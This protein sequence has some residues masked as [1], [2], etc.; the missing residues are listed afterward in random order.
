MKRYR[1]L[2]FDFDARIHTLTLAI[3][4]EWEEGIKEQHQQAKHSV[5]GGLV[6]AY[7]VQAKDAKLQNFIE[8]GDKPFSIL[9]FHNPFFEQLR[10]A[11]VMGAY[12]PAL[13]AVCS[14][15]ERILNYLVL[16][17]SPS[18]SPLA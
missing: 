5:E 18:Y 9:A 16:V 13:T 14:L 15:G 6:Y 17:L 10:T 2:S 3:Q 12:Y 1:V 8:L 11:F 7:G 4:E